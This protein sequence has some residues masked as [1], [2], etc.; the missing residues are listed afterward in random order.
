MHLTTDESGNVVGARINGFDTMPGV[1]SCIVGEAH[2]HIDN[3]D[4]G[5]AWADV[6][7]SFRAE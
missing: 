6:Q 2:V 1:K 3:V 4:T 5:D 7:L